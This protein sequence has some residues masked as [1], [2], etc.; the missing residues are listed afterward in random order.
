MEEAAYI[1]TLRCVN[2]HYWGEWDNVNC[3]CCPI[4]GSDVT[5]MI[6]GPSLVLQDCVRK[7]YDK[8]LSDDQ[9]LIK[10]MLLG[11]DKLYI[12][13]AMNRVKRNNGASRA[14]KCR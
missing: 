12:I 6:G 1:Q 2:N 9:V 5:I 4:C 14:I 7:M 11:F 8:D 10:L 13:S 3:K